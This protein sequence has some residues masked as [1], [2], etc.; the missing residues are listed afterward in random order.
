MSEETTEVTFEA[1]AKKTKK[2]VVKKKR[3]RA[4]SAT[5]ASVPFPGLTRTGNP[6][7]CADAC[8][9]NG[10]VISGINHCAHPCKGGLPAALMNNSTALKRY[11]D[12]KDQIDVRLDPD[13]FK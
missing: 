1:P 10:C 13:R 7:R 12:A 8:N 2:K 6:P 11:Q 9:A 4:P 3:A 5:K